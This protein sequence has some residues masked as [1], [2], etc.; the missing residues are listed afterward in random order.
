[1]GNQFETQIHL[2]SEDD[3]SALGRRLAP[4]LRP[5]DTLL[6]GG[7][8]GAGKTHLARAIIQERLAAAGLSEDVP[9]PTYTL[10]QVYSD[11]ETEIW[12][13]DLYRLG[14]VSEVTELG[15]EEAFGTSI[16]LV[17][18]PERMGDLAPKDALKV[19]LVPENGSRRVILASEDASWSRILPLLETVS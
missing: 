7:P 11:G 9:S 4:V 16:V 19:K 10:V 5:G 18:W 1:M 13:A 14:D 3:T 17:E 6:L 2:M 15:L 8:I 12:H